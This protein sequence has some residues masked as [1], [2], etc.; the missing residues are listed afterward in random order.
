MRQPVRLAGI[1]ANT[2]R[3]HVFPGGSPAMMSRYDVI[4]IKFP[5]FERFTA[6]LA[7]EFIALENILP[8]KLYFFDR[9]PVEKF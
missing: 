2:G 8:V 3:N 9:E 6:V 5:F 7:A 1:T 4:K